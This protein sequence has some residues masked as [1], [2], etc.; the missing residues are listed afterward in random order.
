ME[1]PRKL[2]GNPE[3]MREEECPR[4]RV[5]SWA[6]RATL[7]PKYGAGVLP[8]QHR[9]PIKFKNQFVNGPQE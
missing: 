3:Q 1:D 2:S 9:S 6:S 8:A 7:K 4:R 5:S